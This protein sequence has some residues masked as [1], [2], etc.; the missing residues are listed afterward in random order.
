MSEYQKIRNQIEALQVKANK[1]LKT[2]RQ[3]ALNAL[4]AQIKTFGF[5]AG[6]LGLNSRNKRKVSSGPLAPRSDSRQRKAVRKPVA[7][8]YADGAGNTWSGRGK[9]PLWL[10]AA[11]SNG[12][13][14]ESFKIKDSSDPGL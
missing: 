11:V 10:V 7:P 9:R 6:E 2:E 5:T 4:R 3:D 14:I 13:A 1:I 8:K 12:L